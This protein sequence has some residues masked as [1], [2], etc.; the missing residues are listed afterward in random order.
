[1]RERRASGRHHTR[2][3]QLRAS[4]SRRAA[5]SSLGSALLA[6]ASL[7]FLGIGVQPP[8][9]TWGGML[10]SDLG[11]LAQRPDGP[12]APALAIILTV[13]ALNVLADAVRDR[14]KEKRHG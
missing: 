11:Y 1:M 7:T 4:G 13:G 14:G 2:G 9:P 3:C 10:A 5:I 8:A 6:I 12:L